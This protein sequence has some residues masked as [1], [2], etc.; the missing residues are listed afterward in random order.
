MRGDK[1]FLETPFYGVRQTT[2]HL[3]NE[4]HLVNEKRIRRLMRLMGLMPIYQKPNTSKATNGHNIYPYLLRG[5]RIGRP[6]QVPLSS[7]QAETAEQRV[8]RNHLSAH[9]AWVFIFGRHH[10]PA[11]AQGTGVAYLEHAGS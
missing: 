3:H 1:Q 8:R 6:N 7:P 2:W 9:A 5:L 11:H 10:G 4:D